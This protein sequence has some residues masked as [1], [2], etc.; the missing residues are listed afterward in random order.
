MVVP[1][2]KKYIYFPR[3]FFLFFLPLSFLHPFDPLLTKR[4]NTYSLPLLLFKKIYNSIT[5]EN[6]TIYYKPTRR[7][8]VFDQKFTDELDLMLLLILYVT[9]SKLAS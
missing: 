5:V 8:E 2:P 6:V 1:G 3:Y 7:C 4:I 9:G